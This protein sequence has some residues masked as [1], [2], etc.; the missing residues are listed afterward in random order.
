MTTHGLKPNDLVEASQ[1]LTEIGS[2]L[3]HKMVSRGMKGRQLTRN[4]MD[5]IL[6]ALNHAAGTGY[7]AR[8]AFNYLRPK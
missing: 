6:A 4:V 7:V 1:S 3:T 2:G 8:D 5:K